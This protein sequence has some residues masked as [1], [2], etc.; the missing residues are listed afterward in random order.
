MYF[1]SSKT[2]SFERLYFLPAANPKAIRA[3][4]TQTFCPFLFRGA[5]VSAFPNGRQKVQ[6]R[7]WQSSATATFCCWFGN[8]DCISGSDWRPPTSSSM[9]SYKVRTWGKS[10]D[11]LRKKKP[12]NFSHSKEAFEKCRENPA[13]SATADED[14]TFPGIFAAAWRRPT[15]TLGT[16]AHEPGMFESEKKIQK[17]LRKKFD[18]VWLRS[19]S[20]T[21][22][23]LILKSLQIFPNAW[24]NFGLEMPAAEISNENNL[25]KKLL[26]RC[27]A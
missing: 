8:P 16:C 23:L 20:W 24:P 9:T 12:P 22:G 2:L 25:D 6:A 27:L 19:H 5:K 18:S 26:T 15:L 1:L 21:C 14:R 11:S 13:R 4:K 7:N 3:E 17:S 10:K